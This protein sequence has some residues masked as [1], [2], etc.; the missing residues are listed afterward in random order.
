MGLLSRHAASLEEKAS[1]GGGGEEK[2]WRAGEGSRRRV[3]PIPV[4][5][6]RRPAS[7]AG[8]NGY[9]GSGLQVGIVW[10]GNSGF[11]MTA[12][13]GG[14]SGFP[15]SSLFSRNPPWSPPTSNRRSTAAAGCH[16]RRLLLPIQY[17]PPPPHHSIATVPASRR[18]PPLCPPQLDPTPAVQRVATAALDAI[19]DHLRVNDHP[20]SSPLPSSAISHPASTVSM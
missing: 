20:P 14:S 16:R 5:P 2:R 15:R 6:A 9:F 10:M 1:R 8:L 7:G 12:D 11:L 4:L 19:G 17:A 13:R 3:V 18:P